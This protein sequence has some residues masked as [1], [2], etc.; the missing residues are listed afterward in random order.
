MLN[1]D[2]YEEQIEIWTKIIKEFSDY[3][4]VVAKAYA[5]RGNLKGIQGKMRE[6]DEDY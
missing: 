6:A 4:L 1:A 2:T 3:P 5:N